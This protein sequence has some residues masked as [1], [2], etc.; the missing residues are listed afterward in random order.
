VN[1]KVLSIE[2]RT[3]DIYADIIHRMMNYKVAVVETDAGSII[4]VK[5]FIELPAALQYDNVVP[6]EDWIC[7]GMTVEVGQDYDGYYLTRLPNYE[8]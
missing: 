1:G 2:E 4:E 7:E 6:H 3:T 5:V 8:P